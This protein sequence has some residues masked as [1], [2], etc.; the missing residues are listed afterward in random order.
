MSVQVY[1]CNHVAIEVDDVEKAVAFY[2]DVFNLEKLDEGEGDAF[3]KLG[4]HQFLAMFEV[5]RLNPS[6]SAHFGIMVRDEAQIAEVRDKLTGK[7]GIKLIE[8]FRC[9]FRDPFGNRIQVVDLH[10]ES[11]VWLL[12]YQEVQKVGIKF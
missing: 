6:R 8:G 5:E 7:Y 10:D 11:L 2:Q 4:E 3:F 9:D 12:P 1:G